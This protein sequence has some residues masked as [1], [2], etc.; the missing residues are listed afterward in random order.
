[1]ARAWPILLLASFEWRGRA[2]P[3]KP[4]KTTSRREMGRV[5]SGFDGIGPSSGA[6]VVE[7][8][9]MSFLLMPLN[10]SQFRQTGTI[11]LILNRP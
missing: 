7:Y 6:F 10:L 11:T 2:D 8:A 4:L 1:M 5:P 9:G 3:F